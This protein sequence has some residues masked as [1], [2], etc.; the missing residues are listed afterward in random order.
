MITRGHFALNYSSYDASLPPP[1]GFTAPAA[2]RAPRQHWRQAAPAGGGLA[3]A[4]RQPHLM[5]DP[6]DPSTWQRQYSFDRS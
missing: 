1:L 4:M 6:S 5:M 3:V 2:N